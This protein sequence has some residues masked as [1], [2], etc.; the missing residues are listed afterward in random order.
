MLNQNVKIF[1]GSYYV[2]NVF[3]RWGMIIGVRESIQLEQHEES[4]MNPCMS[5][6]KT[7]TYPLVTYPLMFTYLFML[8]FKRVISK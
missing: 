8:L 1:F 7:V 3:L 2:Y 6:R 5:P 4:L